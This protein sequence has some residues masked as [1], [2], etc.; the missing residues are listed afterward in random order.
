[1]QNAAAATKPKRHRP[2]TL[3]R[4]REVGAEP[5]ETRFGLT[6]SIAEE[7]AE[8]HVQ[9]KPHE[10]QEPLSARL[11]RAMRLS[12]LTRAT[13]AER[14]GIDD[15]TLIDVVL[16]GLPVEAAVEDTLEAWCAT[17]RP[18]S[19]LLVGGGLVRLRDA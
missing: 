19:A 14:A 16:D 18:H 9:R 6:A 5:L 11:R 10:A 4:D 8:R 13:L 17:A 2:Q 15:P 3:P 1:M 12:V 7:L